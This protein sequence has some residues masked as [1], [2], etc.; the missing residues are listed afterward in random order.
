M[1]LT[2]FTGLSIDEL[3]EDSSF[4]S[5]IS[6]LDDTEWEKEVANCSKEDQVV[7]EEA[8]NLV[9]LFC[10]KESV[11]LMP[12]SIKRQLWNRIVSDSRKELVFG[13]VRYGIRQYIKVAAMML[14]ILSI[15]VYGYWHL[16]DKEATYQFSTGEAWIYSDEPVLFLSKGEKIKLDGE[17]KEI[18]VLEKENAVRIGGDSIVKNVVPK[19]ENSEYVLMNEVTVPF[20]RQTKLVLSDGSKVWLNAGSRLAFAQEFRRNNRTVFLEGEGYFEVAKNKNKPFFVKTES[21]IIRVLGTKFNISAY[22]TDDKVE[23][24]LLEGSVKVIPLKSIFNREV[25]IKPGD[26]AIY[27]K[28]GKKM[29]VKREDNI[30]QFISWKDGWYQ[31]SNE[32]IINVLAKLERIY[33]VKFIYN[34]ED[35][36]HTF[37]ISGKLSMYNSIDSVLTNLT[38]VA[39]IEYKMLNDSIFVYSRN[40]TE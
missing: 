5:I 40:S 8:R 6:E 39:G 21:V 34:A 15:G 27:V 19:D 33:N 35:V 29:Q 32:N 24:A 9:R 20:G 38:V 23:T 14:V 11:P 12:S 25:T 3:I 1:K 37:P 26:R 17:K 28:S 18:E 4:L 16:K 10:A 7:L 2:K 31:F 13:A 22:T 36:S 30:E